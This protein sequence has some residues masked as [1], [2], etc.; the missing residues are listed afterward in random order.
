METIIWTEKWSN[1]RW[2]TV[3]TLNNSNQKCTERLQ[4]YPRQHLS[5]LKKN[6]KI[7]CLKE[8]NIYYCSCINSLFVI[9]S[10]KLMTTLMNSMRSGELR[11]TSDI[12]LI[13][14]KTDKT[15]S[16]SFQKKQQVPIKMSTTFY[17]SRKPNIKKQLFQSRNS[18]IQKNHQ[19]TEMPWTYTHMH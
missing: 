14:K 5:L 8:E 15:K 1:R 19:A 12:N 4:I 11:Q 6:Q 13:L 16:L 18:T 7:I 17:P 10:C 9:I 3:N 2:F